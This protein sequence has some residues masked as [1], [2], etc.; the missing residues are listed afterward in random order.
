MASTW[1]RWFFADSSHFGRELK[2]THGA[3]P[4]EHL[5]I[6]HSAMKT[7]LAGP[8]LPDGG[9]SLARR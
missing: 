7:G 3:S 9:Q 4:R 5:R 8:C 2:R 1:R 6:L